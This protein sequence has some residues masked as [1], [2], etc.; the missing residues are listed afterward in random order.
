MKKALKEQAENYFGKLRLTAAL[1]VCN[2]VQRKKFHLPNSQAIFK[3][4]QKKKPKRKL[5]KILKKGFFFLK[6]Q[7][8]ARFMIAFYCPL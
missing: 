7:C 2:L 4:E 5:E 1:S 8:E 3:R 6:L